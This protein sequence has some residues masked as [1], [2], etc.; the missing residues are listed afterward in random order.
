MYTPSIW[1]ICY[2]SKNINDSKQIR[3]NQ[4]NLLHFLIPCEFISDHS[5]HKFLQLL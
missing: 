3:F 2:T 5:V 1:K 4:T